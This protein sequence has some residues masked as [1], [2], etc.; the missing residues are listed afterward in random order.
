MPSCCWL[1]AREDIWPVKMSPSKHLTMA[2]KVSYS[3]K[4]PV[5]NPTCLLQKEMCEKFWFARIRMTGNYNED[6]IGL[7][8][9][10]GNQL[11]RVYLENGH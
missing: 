5:G 10:V 6:W 9:Q 3:P 7:E 2:V 11:T 4:H 1:G 8:N